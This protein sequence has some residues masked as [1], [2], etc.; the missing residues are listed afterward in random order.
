M[1]KLLVYILLIISY[2]A[3]AQKGS[4]DYHVDTLTYKYYITGEWKRLTDSTKLAVN[5]GIDFKY[6]R[7]RAGFANFMIGNFYAS[8]YQYE[9]AINFDRYDSVTYSYL[10]YNAKYN[11]DERLAKY[12][13]K[14]LP[15]SIKHKE[16]LDHFKVFEQV[17][18]E[19]CNKSN[20]YSERGNQSY[21]KI[22]LQSAPSYNLFLYQAFSVFGQNNQSV[23]EIT[24]NKQREISTNLS[25]IKQREYYLKLDYS[26]AAHHILNLHY[27]FV[28]TQIAN[29]FLYEVIKNGHS[30]KT[31][32]DSTYHLN[33][34][35]LGAAYTHSIN[36]F[37]YSVS[38]SIFQYN[39]LLTQ[40]YG[41]QAE[42][43]LPGLHFVRINSELY[44]LRNENTSKLVLKQS[45]GALFF[46]RLWIE[47]N[48]YLGN[49]DYFSDMNGMYIYNSLDASIFKTGITS[50]LRLNKKMSIF[51][52]YSFD[53]KEVDDSFIKYYQNSF[54]AGV[55][56]K[57]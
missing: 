57:F 45:L 10:Y 54:S 55:I 15:V 23:T 32:S 35:L 41:I 52:N 33:G 8:Q 53:R 40:Q 51:G 19:Y 49:L 50:Y 37:K 11:G 47:G 13:S 38:A 12:R 44:G 5:H 29:S 18:L 31:S 26:L 6:L 1:R 39:Q 4:Y 42:L 20:N 28:N 14:S 27:H 46:R 22:G 21:F 3:S 36:R 2:S 24:T 7:Q 9:K 25:N 43:N 30:N 34:N 56:W 16:N 17:D 48:V